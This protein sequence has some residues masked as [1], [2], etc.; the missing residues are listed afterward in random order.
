MRCAPWK[1]YCIFLALTCTLFLVCS[2]FYYFLQPAHIHT[3]HNTALFKK[4][5]SN[6]SAVTK[7][8]IQDTVHYS[9][10][11]FHM[12][13][14]LVSW[15][16]TLLTL[17]TVF[18]QSIKYFH[19]TVYLCNFSQS[20]RILLRDF[21]LNLFQCVFKLGCSQNSLVSVPLSSHMQT[22]EQDPHLPWYLALNLKACEKPIYHRN[23]LTLYYCNTF[24]M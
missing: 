18:L 5:F 13:S 2:L 10:N 19:W 15:G 21:A 1:M 14:W 8:N 17:L 3:S 16:E 24:S 9:V 7:W 20:E 6:L 4:D 12:K 22:A 23:S 11:H